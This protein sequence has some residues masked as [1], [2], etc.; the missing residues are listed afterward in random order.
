MIYS[1]LYGRV[2]PPTSLFL[3]RS[4]KGEFMKESY[5][6]RMEKEQHERAANK[7]R[8]IALKEQKNYSFSDLVREAI[9]YFIKNR[10]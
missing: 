6:I 7:A 8:E 3:E 2:I 10:K 9:D 1:I 4:R 5:M